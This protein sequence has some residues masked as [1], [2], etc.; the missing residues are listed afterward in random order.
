MRVSVVALAVLFIA[1]GVLT[2][3]V[4]VS[5]ATR[6][7]TNDTGIYTVNGLE[8]EE[9]ATGVNF[10]HVLLFQ[11]VQS[12]DFSKIKPYL[13]ANKQVILNIEFVDNHANLAEIAGGNY[14]KYLKPFAD[15]LK[16]D[17]RTIWIRPLHEFNGDWYNWSVYYP[18]NKT[19]DF[20]PAYK[21]VVSVFRDDRAKA[22]FQLNYNRSNSGSA[23]TTP[24]RDFYPGDAW[25]DM[26]VITNYNRA[27]TDSMHQY[28]HSFAEDFMPAYDQVVKLTKKPIGVAEMS[29]TSYGNSKPQ[30][31][32]NTFRAL[33]DQFP[34]VQQITWFAYNRPVKTSLWDWDLNTLADR[35]AFRDGVTLWRNASARKTATPSTTKT[36]QIVPTNS[37][38]AKFL[39]TTFNVR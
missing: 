24:F 27:Y 35:Q 2:D 23:M 39:S 3:T 1:M 14:D 37:A 17:G 21:H 30:W 12:L 19:Q 32:L 22:K 38:E 36:Q 13:D 20:I 31:I 10:D 15:T 26:V 25:V 18:G 33:R 7:Y 29:T 6:N 8:N 34:Q 28:W 9:V 5:G 11:N 16:K 4:R